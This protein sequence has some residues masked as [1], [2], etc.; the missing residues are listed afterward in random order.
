MNE[1][2]GGVL[3]SYCKTAPLL[4]C[5]SAEMNVGKLNAASRSVGVYELD[6]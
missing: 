5:P 2:G 6:P 3:N 1:S 4:S